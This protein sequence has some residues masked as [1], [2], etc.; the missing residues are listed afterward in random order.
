MDNDETEDDPPPP[1]SEQEE[2]DQ[3]LLI[4]PTPALRIHASTNITMELAIK[5]NEKKE[6]KPW[7]EAV[8]EYLHDFTDIFEKA[9]FDEL[10]PHQSWDHAIEL[11]PG[12]EHQLNCKIYP[13]SLDEQRQLDEF[14]NEQLCTRRIC[15]S[16][17]PMASPFFFIK[18]KDGKL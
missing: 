16:K 15:S 18:K 10:P 3:F 11:I 8:P 7:R 1:Y 13:L 9:D 14:L 12:S 6:K 17:L 4:D 2:E 5:A